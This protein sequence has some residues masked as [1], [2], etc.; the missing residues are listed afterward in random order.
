M[1]SCQSLSHGVGVGSERVAPVDAGIVDEDR[2]L[3]ELLATS[4][5]SAAGGAVADVEGEGVRL[6]AGVADLRGGLGRR[7]PLM[8]SAATV[9]PSRA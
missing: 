4:A 8:S 6:A 2:I 9:A 3:A 5:A 1:T 7:P